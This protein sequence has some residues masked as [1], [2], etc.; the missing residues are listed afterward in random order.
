MCPE[1]TRL[2]SAPYD[3]LSAGYERHRVSAERGASWTSQNMRRQQSLG[4]VGCGPHCG[5][6]E[7]GL[8]EQQMHFSQAPKSW[9]GVFHTLSIIHLGW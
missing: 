6:E 9:V 8:A 3:V 4:L 5:S 1:E 2:R 7:P